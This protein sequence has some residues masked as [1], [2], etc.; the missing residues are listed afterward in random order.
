[1]DARAAFNDAA[2]AAVQ[3]EIVRLG[4]S[5]H[6]SRRANCHRHKL[7]TSSLPVERFSSL[8]SD[9]VH[10]VPQVVKFLSPFRLLALALA[11]SCR[12]R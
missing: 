1:M 10:R 4:T 5:F 12:I 8:R 11:A 6:I 3:S 2:L 9:N 7:E